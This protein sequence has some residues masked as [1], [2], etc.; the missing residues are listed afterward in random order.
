MDCRW[1]WASSKASLEWTVGMST[2]FCFD[3]RGDRQEDREMDRVKREI[4]KDEEEG[5]DDT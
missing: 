5:H 1:T 2:I 4:K 3:S